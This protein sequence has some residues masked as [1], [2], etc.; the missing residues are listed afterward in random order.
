MQ[1]LD[2]PASGVQPPLEDARGTLYYSAGLDVERFCQTILELRLNVRRL[3]PAALV[4]IKAPQVYLLAEE[5]LREPRLA[6]DV[7]ELH[8]D[9]SAVVVIGESAG[10]LG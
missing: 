7:A 3:D 2:R 10:A 5:A 8:G 9:L 6:R 4:D 1:V